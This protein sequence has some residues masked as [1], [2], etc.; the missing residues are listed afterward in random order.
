MAERKELP[1]LP[2]TITISTG[3]IIRALL[4][5]LVLGFVYLIRDVVVMF[6]AALFLA[7][8]IDP[9][10]DFLE[11]FKI[12][13]GLAA[14]IVYVVGIALVVGAMILVLPPVL[15]EI[16]NFSVFL[17]PYL[18]AGSEQIDYTQL[19]SVETLALNAEQLLDTVRGAGVAA[20]V[21]ELL[22]LGSNAFGAVVAVIV[23][24]VLAFFL[25][26]EKTALVKAIAFV[27]PAEYQPFV[28]QVSGKMRE[29]LGAWLRGQLLL[30]LVIFAL[31]YIVLSIL[32]IPYAIILALMA[33]LMEII[34][35]IGPWLSAVP[36]VILALS[37]SP[38]HALLTAGAY[39]LIQLAE[40]NI[41]VPKIM[42]KV[43]GLNPIVSL[44]AALVGWRVGGVVGVILAIPLAMAVS[45]FLAEIFRKRA[46]TV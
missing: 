44:L 26:A 36:A 15:V 13:R 5:L 43:S 17:A 19:F 30:M 31:T 35:F 11:R 4:I 34:P 28:M 41:L 23:V 9:F 20:A 40:N 37:I 38:V 45:V 16:Q 18:P 10:A 7:A 39:F 29:S 3:T 46:E 8:L 22:H 14:L 2:Q 1:R 33:G 42:Q 6:F 24:L 25:V 32:G 21:P 12:P 27:A